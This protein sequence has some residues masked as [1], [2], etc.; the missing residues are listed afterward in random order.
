MKL[1]KRVPKE[2]LIVLFLLVFG[3][4]GLA[5]STQAATVSTP[6]AWVANYDSGTVSKVD[7]STN[8][9]SATVAV[10]THPVGVAVDATGNVWVANYGSNSVSRIN[11]STN[12]V[13]N[14]ITVGTNPYG[15]AVDA[16]GNVWVANSGNDTVSKINSST[17]TVS[18]TVSSDVGPKG[19][20][21]DPAGNIWVTNGGVSSVSKINPSTNTVSAT[22]TV[23]DHPYG[24]AVDASGNVWVANNFNDNVSKINSSTNTVTSTI[25]VGPWPYGI[26]V[27]ASGNVWV[28]NNGDGTLSK[29]NTSN[30]DSVSTVAVEDNPAG[31]AVD[32][33][34]NIWTADNGVNKAKKINSLNNT[35]SASVSVGNFPLSLG[36]FTGFAFQYF[37]KGYSID[38][39]NSSGSAKITSWKAYKYTDANKSCSNRLKLIIKGKHFNKDAEV[40]IGGKEALSVSKKSSR[41]ITA[42]FCLAKLSSGDDHKR[43]ITVK[44]PD[45]DEEE[46]DKQIDLDNLLNQTENSNNFDSTTPEGIK[47]IQQALVKLD[48]LDSQ[49]ITGIYGPITTEAVKKLQADNGLPQTGF[50]GPL[51]QAKLAGK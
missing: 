43:K 19:V 14:T 7:T 8:T 38:S 37:V 15:L 10:G 39:D 22:V 44:N 13:T 23:G 46:A 5:K 47:N 28:S 29:I 41:E 27:D 40:R 36:D 51:T 30:G 48:Y 12:I 9:V 33:S 11:S 31:I 3:S 50:V 49:Y 18:A 25:D 34:G 21:V 24:I 20:A 45:A 1:N 16:S 32:A 6:Y 4:L 42:K 17:N 26:A 2:F 35:V